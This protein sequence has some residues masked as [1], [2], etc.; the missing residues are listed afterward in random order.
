MSM[1]NFPKWVVE[2]ITSQMVHLFLGDIGED[3]KYHL[4]NWGLVSRKKDLGVPNLKDFDMA[5]L[6]SWSKVFL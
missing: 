5:L 6:A 2:A 1:I 4:A 3:H